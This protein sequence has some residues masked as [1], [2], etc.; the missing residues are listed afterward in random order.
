[1]SRHQAV[2]AGTADANLI[3]G[4]IAAGI[5]AIAIRVTQTQVLVQA[6]FHTS[7]V[8]LGCASWMHR[9]N[10]TCRAGSSRALGIIHVK[11]L[12]QEPARGRAQHQECDAGW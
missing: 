8:V 6:P 7:C 11:P 10:I 9:A 2:I 5:D 1:M 3:I 4:T 12:A